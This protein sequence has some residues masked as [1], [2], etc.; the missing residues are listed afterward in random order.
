M[1]RSPQNGGFQRW[2]GGAPLAATSP[3]APAM[4]SRPTALPCPS[5]AI[6][7]RNPAYSSRDRDRNSAGPPAGSQ[8]GDGLKQPQG[9]RPGIPDPKTTRSTNFPRP[10]GARMAG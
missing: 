2:T 7:S 4:A 5:F 1:S 10:E 9:P 3:T 6:V 8:L